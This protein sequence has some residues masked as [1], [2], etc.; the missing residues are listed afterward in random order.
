M[1]ILV[2]AKDPSLFF[3]MIQNKIK[4]TSWEKDNDG[5]YCLRNVLLKRFWI[6]PRQGESM[7]EYNVIFGMLG[8][9]KIFTTKKDYS[10]AHTLFAQILLQHFDNYIS[11]LE[12]TI[13]PTKYDNLTYKI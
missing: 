13:F 8:N 6:R 9:K 5:D 11:K 7:G 2:V 12:L 10:D 1:A 4:E 3:D